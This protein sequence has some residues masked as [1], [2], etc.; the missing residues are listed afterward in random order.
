MVK[1]DIALA[2]GR[3]TLED[4]GILRFIAEPSLQTISL[5]QLKELL[6]VFIEI[7]EGKPRPFF[8]DNTNMKT[9]GHQKRKYIGDNLHLFAVAS[10]AKEN[11]TTVRFIGNAINH[12]FTPKVP[13]RMFKSEDAAIEWLKTF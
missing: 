6:H 3:V 2:F 4:E 5:S 13:M 10:A 7:T 8:S 1:K 11:S 12:L 9:L